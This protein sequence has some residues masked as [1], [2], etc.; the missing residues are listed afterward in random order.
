[1]LAHQL[2]IRVGVCNGGEASCRGVLTPRQLIAH[3][4]QVAA[5][6]LSVHAQRHLVPLLAVR[7]SYVGS[8]HVELYGSVDNALARKYSTFGIY[9]T[10]SGLPMPAGTTTLAITP[11]CGPG[12][13]IGWVGVR[14]RL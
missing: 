13:P 14:V 2:R 9:T 6:P 5:P 7:T 1:M 8:D 12:A 3:S 11:S 10:E 4:N